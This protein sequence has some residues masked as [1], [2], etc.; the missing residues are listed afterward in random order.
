MILIVAGWWQ[1]KNIIR[2]MLYPLTG[3]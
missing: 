1:N 3:K 2:I